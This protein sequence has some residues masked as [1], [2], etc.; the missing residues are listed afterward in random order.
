M[1]SIESLVC[2]RFYMYS[3]ITTWAPAE[4]FMGGGGGGWQIKKTHREKA[5]RNNYAPYGENGSSTGE[6][7]TKMSP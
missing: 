1:H 5:S 4:I 7:V 3:M 6:K 2:F